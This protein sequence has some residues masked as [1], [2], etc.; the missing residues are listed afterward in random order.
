MLVVTTTHM[1]YGYHRRNGVPASIKS[2]MTEYFIRHGTEMTIMQFTEDP[3]YL[4]EVLARTT[5]F[6]LNPG[7][8]V[9]APGAG[10]EIAEE[11]SSWPEGYV[12]HWPWG[13]KHTEFANTL[14]IPFE[15]S[16]GL[17]EA[18]YPEYLPML[19]KMMAEQA[20]PHRRAANEDEIARPSRRR[21]HRRRCDR[22]REVSSAQQQRPPVPPDRLP[23]YS[24]TPRP[25]GAGQV[26]VLPVQ[27]N[28]Y[29]LNL[30]DVNI[31]AQ[32]GDDG[33]LLVDSGPAD[34]SQKVIDTIRDRFGNR[35]LRYI[36]NTHMHDDA[37]GGNAALAAALG[38]GGGGGFGG[39]GGGGGVRIIA[40]ETRS[41]G[42]RAPSK[43]RRSCRR[44]GCRP[45][46]FSEE[47]GAL[48]QRRA[49]RG[50]VS[51]PRPH[52]RRRHGVLPRLGRDCD[53]GSVLH[54]QL[55]RSSTR[56]AARAT[57]ATSTR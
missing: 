6:Q 22:A 54:R 32:V 12:P 30:G 17:K 18:M 5:D 34:W 1:K 20:K 15:A 23:V 47:E 51:R 35:P 25:A 29:M 57:R 39:G 3:V 26:G 42:C 36:V 31:V 40:H 41:T 16:R 8:N 43:A 53:G 7:Q 55:S 49:D 11:I 38:P 28:V 19:R 24:T 21:C 13:T 9:G 44:N 27:G 50:H 56:S 2:K 33:I 4:E 37:T 48:L 52:R 14:G 10:F 45:L 46:P